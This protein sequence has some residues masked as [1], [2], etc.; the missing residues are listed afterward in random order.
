VIRPATPLF[1][2]R[3]LY[4]RSG[5][6]MR[7]FVLTGRRQMALA[8]GLGAAGLWMGSSAPAPTPGPG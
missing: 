8:G 7:A 5:G 3:H 2:E 6:E 1:P 4:F